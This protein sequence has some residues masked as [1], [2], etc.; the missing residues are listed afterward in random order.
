MQAFIGGIIG[1]AEAIKIFEEA[2]PTLTAQAARSHG[3]QCSDLYRLRDSGEVLELSRGVFRLASAPAVEL[4][5][6]VAV[7]ARS[8]VSQ[9]ERGVGWWCNTDP[10]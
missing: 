7:L 2:G 8:H 6:V 4:L 1:D 9:F 3:L 5:D 10:T